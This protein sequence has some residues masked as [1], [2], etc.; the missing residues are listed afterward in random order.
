V[1]LQS[2]NYK[3]IETTYFAYSQTFVEISEVKLCSSAEENYSCNFAT[4]S[5]FY[6]C[7]VMGTRGHLLPVKGNALR[8]LDARV[9]AMVL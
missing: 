6:K 3:N 1:I 7:K 4:A 9:P 5:L 2:C 8:P